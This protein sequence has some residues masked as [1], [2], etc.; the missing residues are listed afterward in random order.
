M[1]TIEQIETELK[2]KY[3]IVNI[4]EFDYLYTITCDNTTVKLKKDTLKGKRYPLTIKRLLN[5]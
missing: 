4:K 5:K 3:N 1:V 2:T